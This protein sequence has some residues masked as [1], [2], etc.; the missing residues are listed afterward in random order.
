MMETLREHPGAAAA[1]ALGGL[2]VCLAG[3]A[4]AIRSLPA[5]HFVARPRGGRWKRVMRNLLGGLL[6][7]AGVFLSLPVVPG[8]G[9]VVAVLGL[10]LLDFPGKRRMQR[11]LL[12]RKK[13]AAGLNRVRR[14]VRR[15][16]FR[17]PEASR[18]S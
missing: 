15:P 17:F 3:A 16:P 6:V 14:W 4:L 2:L 1:V 13:V 18:R 8:P 5:D 11:K 9:F 12:A 7:G 10:S